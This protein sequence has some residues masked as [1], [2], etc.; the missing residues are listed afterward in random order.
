MIVFRKKGIIV[1]LALIAM[2]F[3][4]VFS[5]GGLKTSANEDEFISENEAKYIAM[6]HVASTVHLDKEKKFE[7]WADFADLSEPIVMSDFTGSTSAYC[8]G[9][10]DS[11]GDSSGYVVVGAKKETA[12]IVEFSTTGEFYPSV[13][14]DEMKADRIIYNGG[15]EYYLEKGYD[16]IDISGFGCAQFIS[17]E[18]SLRIRE[19]GFVIEEHQEEWTEWRKILASFSGG[20]TPPES[21][22]NNFITDP[23]SYEYGYQGKTIYDVSGYNIT[24]RTDSY[25]SGY[26][27]HCAPIAATNLMK[28]WYTRNTS[29]Y[30][31]LRKYADST[32]AATFLDY[33]S[34]MST[35]STTGTLNTNLVPAY[36]QYFS[37]AG[38]TGAFAFVSDVTWN[39]IKNELNSDYPFH[40]LVIGHYA[41]GNHSVVA[42]GYI[43]FNYSGN[44][45]SSYIRVADGWIATPTRFIHYA[46]GNDTIHMVRVRPS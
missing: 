10:I 29:L 38:V 27:N 9:V 20:S 4:I 8:F 39:N 35:S 44:Y 6:I 1:I 5:F 18:D 42:L 19:E 34:L 33:S 23:Y 46:I 3:M 36:T 43:R 21:G 12:P 41:Y 11:E 22:S 7:E 32:W 2:C 26:P 28:Y 17:A 24:Y 15:Y 30:Y 16:I 25:F 40:M 14:M 45:G 37:N 13:I 31:S